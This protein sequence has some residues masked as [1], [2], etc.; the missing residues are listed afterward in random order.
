[1]MDGMLAG[2]S[3]PACAGEPVLAP[4][5]PTG[6]RV[7]PRVCGGTVAKLPGSTDAEGLSPRVRGN[8]DWPCFPPAIFGS[9]PACAGNR[10][11]V[12][13]HHSM[14]GSIPACAGE[15][16]PWDRLLQ[17]LRVYPRVCGGTTYHGGRSGI[18]EGLS[19]RVRGNRALVQGP[20]RHAGS[21]P[22]CA[23]E[24]TRRLARPSFLPVYPRV[25]G[26]TYELSDASLYCKGL[27]PRVRG[28]PSAPEPSALRPRSIPACA[29]EPFL[30]GLRLSSSR[31]YPRVC[32]GTER[33]APMSIEG[34]GLS[35]RVRGNPLARAARPA[36]IRSIPACAGE[37]VGSPTTGRIWWVY[38][39]VCGGTVLCTPRIKITPKTGSIPACAGEPSSSPRVAGGWLESGLSPR[40][41]GNLK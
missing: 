19:P 36:S 2:R 33:V 23:G 41:R 3:I 27:S 13:S 12:W 16:V 7:Y 10:L 22:A 8:L 31:V 1:M 14:V 5:A 28:N 20:V 32:G 26:G 39:R 4:T 15:P 6:A 9:I 38:P 18:V 35:P 11:K 24:P 17:P 30:K 40:V 21:I 37:P 25:C 34:M 29:G